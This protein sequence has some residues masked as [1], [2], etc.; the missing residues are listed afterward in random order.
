MEKKMTRTRHLTKEVFVGN[1]GI[2]GAHP[3]R[4]QAMTNTETADIESTVKQIKELT[5]AGSELVRLT[6]NTHAAAKAIP[7]IKE[8]LLRGGISI[9][10]IGDFHFNGHLLLAR[11]PDCAATLDK[12]RINPGT[13]SGGKNRDRN[14]R[15]MIEVAIT[16]RKPV[17][18]GVNWGSLDQELLEKLMDENAKQD[19]PRSD[20]EVLIDAAVKSLL[21]SA[22]NAEA[23][24]LPSDQIIVS[25]KFSSMDDL[26]IANRLIAAQCSYPIHLGLTEAG[27]G[28]SGIVNSTAALTK[29]LSEGIGDTIRVSLTPSPNGP[30]T[31]EVRVCQEVLRALGLRNLMP[32]IS[33]CPGCGRTTSKVFI[34]LAAE[35]DRY[36]EAQMPK[37]RLEYPGVE[38][39]RI[40]VMGCVVNGPGESKHADIGISLPGTGE[41]P[42]APVYIDG[43]LF[44][45]LKGENIAEEFCAILEN[46]ISTT[47]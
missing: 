39:L 11:Y 32:S 20:K 47:Y 29:I 28:I 15:K 6:V 42:R 41:I 8:Q 21:E 44:S 5:A 33:A 12:Y 17:R 4:I 30:R 43:G 9:P 36:I 31:D 23:C 26:V 22:E 13:V 10:L 19:E 38:N 7:F 16:H 18:I 40:A 27:M 45:T 35:V 24:G 25:A 3:V 46:Y 14:F 1:V 34:E 2:G 37:W